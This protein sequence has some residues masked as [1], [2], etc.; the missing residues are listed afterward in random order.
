[1]CILVFHVYQSL[2]YTFNFAY[3]LQIIFFQ[4]L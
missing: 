1:M 4:Q 3:D 2:F